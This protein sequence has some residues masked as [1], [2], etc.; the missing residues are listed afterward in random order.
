MSPGLVHQVMKAIGHTIGTWI[1]GT[2]VHFLLAI[3]AS[4]AGGAFAGI[5]GTLVALPAGTPIEARG[6]ST[7]QGAV[8]TMQAI[9]TRGTQAMVAILLV[10]ERDPK[11]AKVRPWVAK[12]YGWEL[13]PTCPQCL[14]MAAHIWAT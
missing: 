9:V 3:G 6:V 14:P 7:A 4:E 2:P 11:G 5:A 1:V 10:L 8:F 12:M 13:G